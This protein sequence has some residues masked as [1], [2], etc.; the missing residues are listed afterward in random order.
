[1]SAGERSSTYQPIDSSITPRFA[2]PSTFM[3]L[4]IVSGAHE[5][6]I[7]IYGVPWDGGTTNRPGPRHGPR[8]VRE[9][10]SMIRRFHGVTRVSPFELCR[11][12]DFGDAPTNPIDL[13]RS[14][15]RSAPLR[16]PSS[17]P[18][19]LPSPSEEIISVLYRCY[20]RSKGKRLWV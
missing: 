8:Q 4:P 1:M 2:G 11:V 14:L 12:A 6:D 10:S 18:V 7:A 20:G 16:D 17:R 3:R 5:T 19:R 15:E 13:L 9:M